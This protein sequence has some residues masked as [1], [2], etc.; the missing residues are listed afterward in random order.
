MH[1]QGAISETPVPADPL[2]AGSAATGVA[3]LFPGQGS[4][5]PEMR[6][7]VAEHR[8]DLLEVATEAC[9]GDPF[10]RLE[11]GTAF[12]QPAMYAAAIAAWERAGRPEAIAMAGHSLGELPA[13]AAAGA[14]DAAAGLRLAAERGRI[15]QRAAESS[16]PGGMLAVLGD[17]PKTT[18]MARELE[19]TIANH[20]APGQLVLSGPAAQLDAAVAAAR[21]RRLKTMKLPIA[22]AF[23]SPAMREAVPEFREQLARTEFEP[24]SVPVYSC[25][26]AQPFADI[27]AT[28]AE[29]LVRPVRWTETLKAL[30]AA[31]AGRFLE[32]GPG[33]V[34]TGLVRRTLPDAEAVAL[35][36]TDG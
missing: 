11:D 13:L 7:L 22:G 12:A 3:L 1:A 31:G 17:E 2:L 28:L 23:H 19:L 18:G 32:A 10:E 5:T 24:P 26:T 30:E 34:L 21:E 8:S 9:G 14:V 25:T 15:M 16:V 36:A 33:K 29:A 20:N 6:E 4:Q 35:E 27:R